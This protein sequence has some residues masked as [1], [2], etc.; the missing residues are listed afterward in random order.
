[1]TRNWKPPRIFV[2]VFL[3]RISFDAIDFIQNSIHVISELDVF[4]L[5]RNRAQNDTSNREDVSI[6]IRGV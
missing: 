4:H 1:M 6:G 5:E 3:S 2:V